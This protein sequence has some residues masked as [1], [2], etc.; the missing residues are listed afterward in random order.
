MGRV[1][2]A[3]ETHPPREVALKVMRGLSR[4]ALERFHREIDLLGQ[5]EHP[6]IVRLYAAGEDVVGGLPSPWLALEVVRGPDLHGYLPVSYTHLEVYKRQRYPRQALAWG[7]HHQPADRQKS[8]P[9]ARHRAHAVA[10][11][12]AGGLVHGCLLYTSRC[13]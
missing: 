13:V 1:Y 12:R 11:Q 6:G 10:A 3:R 9:V 8:V 2:L 5:L 7:Q 4:T